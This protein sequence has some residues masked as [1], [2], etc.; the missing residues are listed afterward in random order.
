MDYLGTVDRWL[1]TTC[2]EGLS[3]DPNYV[4]VSVIVR[5]ERVG[6]QKQTKVKHK[7]K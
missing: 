3:K 6:Q 4:A 2:M 5:E 1:C 7:K